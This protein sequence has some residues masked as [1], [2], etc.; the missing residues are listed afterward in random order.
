MSKTKPLA[1][2]PAAATAWAC[3]FAGAVSLSGQTPQD[4]PAAPQGPAPRVATSPIKTKRFTVGIRGRLLPVRSL[5]VMGNNTLLDT[6]SLPAPV[7]DYNYVTTTHSAK[8]GAGV[9]LDYEISPK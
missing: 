4:A 9:S 5:S 7:R 3:L 2:L 6:I 8:W 1:F